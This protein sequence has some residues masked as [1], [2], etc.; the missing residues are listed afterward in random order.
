MPDEKELDLT[1]VVLAY[2]E[3]QLIEATVLEIIS[4]LEAVD[5]RATILIMDDGSIGPRPSP[6]GW[7]PST[8]TSAATITR[9]TSASPPTSA[10]ASSW[11]RPPGTP[12]SRG[13][14]SSS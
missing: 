12:P 4:M 5:R 8:A 1:F 6:T 3:E 2:N 13:T 9:R 14:T 11:W 10:R 7:S